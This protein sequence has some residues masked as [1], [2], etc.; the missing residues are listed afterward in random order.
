MS[1]DTEE[2]GDLGRIR[3][4]SP[5]FYRLLEE[6]AITHD[7]KSHDYANNSNPSGNYHFAGYVAG[8]FSHSA[9]DAGFVGR[10]AEKIYRLS[11]LEGS[12]KIPKN[13]SIEDTEV[14]ICTIVTLWMADRRQRRAKSG[15]MMM[16]GA[17]LNPEY[18]ED[19]QLIKDK[20]LANNPLQHELY[21][22]LKLMPDFQTD[23]L[24]KF[25]LDMR[26][27][28]RGHTNQE[29]MTEHPSQGLRGGRE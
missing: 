8:L 20:Q 24:M 17:G 26:Q 12:Q 27:I 22:L 25:I 6:M 21:D 13:E 5:D 16:V 11:V 19:K 28:R 9:E 14:D 1:Y 4:G 7:K 10:V 18:R 15:G 3:H 29:N 23:D 2:H